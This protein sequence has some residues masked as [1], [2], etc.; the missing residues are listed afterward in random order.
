VLGSPGPVERYGLKIKLHIWA[1][2]VLLCV[3]A[4]AW[5][6]TARAQAVS[7]CLGASSW[8]DWSDYRGSIGCRVLIPSVTG[9][10]EANG[11]DH[12]FSDYGITNDTE[13]FKS[14]LVS[15][16]VDRL[17]IWAEIEEDHKF[18][19]RTGDTVFVEHPLRISEFD[20]SAGKIGVDLDIIRYP[21][22]RGGINFAYHLTRIEFFDRRSP[23]QAQ[24]NKYEGENAMT[25]GIHG[26]AFPLRI[27]DIPV[28]VAARVRFPIPFL[29]TK[30]ETKITEW[31]VCGGL[32]PAIWE[33]SLLGHSTFSFA[34]EG[35]YRQTFLNMRVE[36]AFGQETEATVDAR[37]GGPFI[38]ATL[39]Y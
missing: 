14:L 19:G 13:L 9:H 7:S 35:G 37:W 38:Q 25:L 4:L 27:R 31:E 17:G 5:P 12:S 36:S 8:W 28:T 23:N 6:A 2:V 10:V 26:R 21:F 33:T 16:Y 32:R 39:V 3:C 20:V 30:N 24:W 15:F 11:E 29:N 34:L 22:V 1:P 18:Y